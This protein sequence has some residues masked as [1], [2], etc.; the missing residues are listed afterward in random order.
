MKWLAL[1]TSFCLYIN[2]YACI[3]EYRTLLN[4][5]VV[6]KEGDIL[7]PSG[8]F[9]DNNQPYLKDEL[10]KAENR[11]KETGSIEDYSDWGALLVYNGNYT[12][13]KSVF[14]SIEAKEPGRYVT[15]S[16]LGTVY[17]LLGDNDSAL[18]WIKKGYALNPESHQ[19]SEWIHIKILEAKIKANNNPAYYLTHSILNLDFGNDEIPANKNNMLLDTVRYHLLI[20][21]NERMSFVKPKDM[22]V[23][24]LLFD[25]GNI[26]AITEDVKSGY[27]NF[28]LAKMYGYENV[29]M[30]K[31]MAVF[32]RMQYKADFINIVDDLVK[33]NPTT[34]LLILFGLFCAGCVF[35]YWIVKRIR[36][37]KAQA[38]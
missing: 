35:I 22:V 24:Q 7:I 8:R 14:I 11:Y 38:H 2:T 25:L 4:G 28:K 12:L 36:K 26:C 21:L 20:Q 29:L 34:T 31:R 16:N 6:M 9:N 37:N 23:G 33:G 5:K 32:N 19:R 10:Y 1:V 13:A 30:E 18:Y 15:A 3:N 27:E 17:E